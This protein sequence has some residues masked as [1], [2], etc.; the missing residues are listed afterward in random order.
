[1][2]IRLK[3]LTKIFK[4]NKKESETHRRPGGRTAY[5]PGYFP[6]STGPPSVCRGRQ[7]YGQT[8]SL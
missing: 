3:N 6:E 1:M 8:C 7:S 4:D 5:P 2:E